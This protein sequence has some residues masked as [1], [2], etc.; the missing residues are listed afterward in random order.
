MSARSQ[1]HFIWSLL[2]AVPDP[3]GLGGPYAGVSQGN[4]L[5][6]GGTNFARAPLWEGGMKTWHDTVYSLA[7]GEAQWQKAG[8]LPRPMGYGVS[9]TT[10]RG[11]V[12]IGGADA[13]QHYAD[14]HLLQSEQESLIS[15]TLPTL[16][17][18][19][20]YGCGA[21]LGDVLYVAGGLE[22]PSSTS[23]LRR[24]WAL[25]LAANLLRW[26]EIEPWPGPERMLAVAAVQDES[27]FLFSGVTLAANG[28]CPGTR[29]YLRDAYRF[30][31]RA[32]WKRIADVPKPIVA[33]PSPAAPLG[34]TKIMVLGA[35]DGSNA[36]FQPVQFHPGFSRDVFIYDV[37]ANT[38]AHAEP[39][40][41]A[42]ATVP[43]V[44][45]ERRF[46]IPGGELRPGIRSR[47]VW[48]IAPNDY[49][50]HPP[51][52]SDSRGGADLDESIGL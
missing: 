31:P 14:V 3:L 4:L 18:P 45:W 52:E 7:A 15:Q 49:R 33:A 35:D 1:P 6:A 16:P 23:T 2:P 12:C 17:V 51:T 22:S 10:T 19:M 43:M 20:A 9:I 34:N 28:Q 41:F 21:R 5:V 36:G 47:H 8:T 46:I 27:F 44:E 39:A 37:H 25:D 24:F 26:Q 40:P 38:W 42:W 50:G 32:G 30:R 48:A 29:S 13:R 11:L